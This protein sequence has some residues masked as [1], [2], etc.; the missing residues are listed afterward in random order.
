MK[1]PQEVPIKCFAISAFLLGKGK[2]ETEVLLLKRTGETLGGEWCQVAGRIES[3]E[4]AWE[5]ALREI[6]EETDLVPARFY[7]GDICEQF[8]EHDEE[9]ISLVPV[10]VGYIES[11][12]QV[13]LNDE[14]SEFRWVSFEEASMMLPFSGQRKV[15]EH[16]REAFVEDEPTEWLRIQSP[17]VL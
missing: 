3:G 4:T 11:N 10:F 1:N 7:S 8:Y 5:A 6:K 17:P 2:D 12:Q 14:H 16:I 13:R 9:C 15:L